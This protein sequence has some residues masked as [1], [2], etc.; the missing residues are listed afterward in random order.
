MSTLPSSQP[1]TVYS[2]LQKD[3]AT[4]VE[5]AA[6]SGGRR[7]VIDIELAAG[8]GNSPHRHL[9]YAERFEVLEGT[10]T[11]RLGE[12]TFDLLPGQSATAPVGAVHCFANRTSEPARFRVELAPGHHGFERA[13]QV[14]YGLQAD[15]RTDGKGVPRNP[16]VLALLLKWSDM[17]MVGPM[18]AIEPVAGLLARIA[19]R[20]GIERELEE[21]YCRF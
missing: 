16:L 13:L 19:R 8:G 14:G 20:R 4:F 15:G 6:E 5:T 2:P 21:R 10:L 18:R 11:V 9:T 12:A 1:R 3:Y 17:A 7:T